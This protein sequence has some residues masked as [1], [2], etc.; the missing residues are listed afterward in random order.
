MDKKIEIK[1]NEVYGFIHHARHELYKLDI[2]DSD[3]RI[4]LPQYF[5]GM[6]ISKTMEY[7][8]AHRVNKEEIGGIKYHYHW[9]NEIVVYCIS[10]TQM[11]DVPVFKFPLKR[12][13]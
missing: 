13:K 9:E 11:G 6:M 1:I 5:E 8:G 2:T 10:R 12:L 7:F 3:I 4:A